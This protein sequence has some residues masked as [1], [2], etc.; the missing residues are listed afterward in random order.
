[1]CPLPGATMLQCPQGP[2]LLPAPQPHF[3]GT[4]ERVAKQSAL[5]RISAATVVSRRHLQIEPFDPSLYNGAA[6]WTLE[7]FMGIRGSCRPSAL[8][9]LSPAMGYTPIFPVLSRRA[10]Q[11][12][13]ALRTT[14]RCFLQG[15][16][17]QYRKA[18]AVF[19]RYQA[20]RAALLLYPLCAPLWLH[21]AKYHIK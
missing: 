6:W 18:S 19:Y 15:G 17:L 12:D 11:E 16:T 3:C 14:K 13:K 1:M 2:I 10:T 4:S 20:L 8:R 21:I 5:S 9:C 7:S